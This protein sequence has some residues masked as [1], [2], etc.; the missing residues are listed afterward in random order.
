MQKEVKAVLHWTL[1][2]QNKTQGFLQLTMTE[3]TQQER[4]WC[5]G[6]QV[7]VSTVL[8]QLRRCTE[9]HES[10]GMN[11]DTAADGRMRREPG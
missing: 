10:H 9:V 7:E 5:G 3:L 8:Q 4:S 2:L 6:S 11:M 1:L